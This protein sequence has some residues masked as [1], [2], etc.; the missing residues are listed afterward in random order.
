MLSGNITPP[1]SPPRRTASPA[2]PDQKCNPESNWPPKSLIIEI[3]G[4]LFAEPK[5]HQKHMFSKPDKIP[6]NST[7][8]AQGLNFGHFLAPFGHPFFI[9]F[10]DSPKPLKLQQAW[11]KNTTFT[12][13]GLSFRQRKS[14][15]NSCFFKTP[16]WTLFFLILHE[17]MPKSSI[18][19]PLQNPL[20]CKIATKIRPSAPK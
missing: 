7:M 4:G 14:I 11:C 18:L 15:E 9:K 12:T 13:S 20:G 10:R 8:G 3:F 5:T 1:L 16:S 19:G 2:D 17:S 6:T